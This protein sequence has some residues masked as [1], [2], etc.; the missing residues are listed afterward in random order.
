MKPPAGQKQRGRPQIVAWRA[1][2]CVRMAGG[3]AMRTG[4]GSYIP[5]TDRMGTP[6]KCSAQ[7]SL[8]PSILERI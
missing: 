1:A 7:I 6:V 8:K 2:S 3:A 5:V 4:I